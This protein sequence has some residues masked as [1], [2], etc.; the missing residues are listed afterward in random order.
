M[1]PRPNEI[2]IPNA[3]INILITFSLS[4]NV[5]NVGIGYNLIRALVVGRCDSSSVTYTRVLDSTCAVNHRQ[6]RWMLLL[7]L[8]HTIMIRRGT[9]HQISVRGYLALGFG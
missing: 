7:M 6:T 4:S 9:H 1:V 3:N 5:L 2:I 8:P